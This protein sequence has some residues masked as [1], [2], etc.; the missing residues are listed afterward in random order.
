MLHPTV[1]T[2]VSDLQHIVMYNNI[3]VLIKFL[4]KFAAAHALHHRSI[5]MHFPPAAL[6]HTTLCTV[7]CQLRLNLR[8][9]S[10]LQ[11]PV[12]KLRPPSPY[13]SSIQAWYHTTSPSDS[14]V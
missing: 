11:R 9:C 1:G 8:V 10:V 6:Q 13:P 12:K 4:D 5:S 2:P 7:S 14:S 3:L